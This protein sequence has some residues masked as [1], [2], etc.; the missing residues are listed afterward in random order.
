M[1]LAIDL[2]MVEEE[3]VILTGDYELEFFTEHDESHL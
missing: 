1:V 3:S 2:T